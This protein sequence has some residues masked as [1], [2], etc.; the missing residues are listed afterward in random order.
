[1][2]DL[3]ISVNTTNSTHASHLE[4]C[5]GN[6]SD[7]HQVTEQFDYSAG[8]FRNGKRNNASA[9]G[10]AEIIFDFDDGMTFDEGIALFKEYKALLVT[11][12][13]HL[14]EKKGVISERFRV[15]LPL[16]HCIIDMVFYTKLMRVLTRHFKSD[17]AC[18]DAS[19]YYLQNPNQIVHYT[20]GSKF[21]DISM[22]DE[23]IDSDE[24]TVSAPCKT[25]TT[26][27]HLQTTGSTSSRIDLSTLLHE[28]VKYTFQGIEH[29]STLEQVINTHG[30]SDRSISCRCFLNPE[31]EDINPSCYIYLNDTNVY[32][33]CVAC[34]TDGLLNFTRSKE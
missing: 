18:T 1:M 32:A 19:R 10:V 34:G 15:I 7:L 31:H 9:F 28:T 12:K 22:F 2:T 27:R 29:S 25:S 17:V 23:M 16:N 24:N 13:S 14:K 20:T 30:V 5:F 33:K 3:S 26:S 8:L 11:T 4:H 6:W 21:F